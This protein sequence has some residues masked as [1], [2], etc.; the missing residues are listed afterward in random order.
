[1]ITYRMVA[2]TNTL[3]VV[4]VPN[5]N[6]DPCSAKNEKYDNLKPIIKFEKNQATLFVA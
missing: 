6:V 5:S 3:S 4:T 2:Q 1:M